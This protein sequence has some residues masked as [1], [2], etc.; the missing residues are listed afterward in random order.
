[1]RAFSSYRPEAGLGVGPR[2]SPLPRPAVASPETVGGLTNR[3][4]ESRRS[5][6]PPLPGLA[7]PPTLLARMLW[8]RHSCALIWLRLHARRPRTHT[9]LARKRLKH[10][11]PVC[12]PRRGARP[13]PRFWVLPPPPSHSA[14]RRGVSLQVVRPPLPGGSPARRTRDLGRSGGRG[15]KGD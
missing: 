14:R 5:S 12:L 9:C 15:R 8:L 4:Q 3:W 2:K 1:M 7:P 6:A 13:L 11:A 10:A